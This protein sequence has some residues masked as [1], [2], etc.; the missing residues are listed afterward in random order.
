MLSW[1][2]ELALFAGAVRLVWG[3]PMSRKTKAKVLIAFACRLFII[4]PSAVR[5]PILH[6]SVFSSDP[7]AVVVRLQV[8]SLF[9]CQI[10]VIS[11]TVPCAKPF[12]SVFASGILG[13]PRTS[14]LPVQ[15]PAMR[16]DTGVPTSPRGSADYGYGVHRLQ[17]R[18]ERGISFATAEHVPVS[19]RGESHRPSLVNSKHSSNSIAYSRDFE[20]TFQDV[21]GL[22]N[23]EDRGGNVPEEVKARGSSAGFSWSGSR[24]SGRKSSQRSNA[25]STHQQSPTP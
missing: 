5:L 20:V 7:A 24:W 8:M 18:P 6:S 13:R 14:I 4:P 22:L 3:I 15:R 21:G 11:A 2:L 17:L 12:F 9:A 19:S 25:T 10:S 23:Q 16:K 1:V